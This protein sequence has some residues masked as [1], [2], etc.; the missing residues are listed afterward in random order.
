[1][2][3]LV[4]ATVHFGRAILLKKFLFRTLRTANSKTQLVHNL[5]KTQIRWPFNLYYQVPPGSKIFKHT[6]S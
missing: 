2:L 4:N 5:L 1:M 6:K 3:I